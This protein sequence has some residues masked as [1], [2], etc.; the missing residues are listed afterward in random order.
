MKDT[1]VFHRVDDICCLANNLK[2]IMFGTCIERKTLYVV[3]QLKKRKRFSSLKKMYSKAHIEPRY[4]SLEQCSMYL[5]RFI[6]TYHEWG[7]R[8]KLW[9]ERDSNNKK[10]K[11]G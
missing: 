9:Y 4:G 6:G 1:A 2:F 11:N 5:K 8:P 10:I 3:I 7:C